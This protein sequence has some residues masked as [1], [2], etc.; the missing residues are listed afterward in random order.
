ME[1]Y[2]VDTS[3]NKLMFDVQK[4]KFQKSTSNIKY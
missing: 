4:R 2:N 1:S 3:F